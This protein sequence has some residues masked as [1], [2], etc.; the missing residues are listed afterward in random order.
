MENVFLVDDDA[1][2]APMP[3][4]LLQRLGVAA[5]TVFFD[6]YT[7]VSGTQYRLHLSPRSRP[8]THGA[9]AIASCFTC[10]SPK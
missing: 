4:P 8:I 5:H 3:K 9:L 2:C 10:A 6:D 1:G 7:R